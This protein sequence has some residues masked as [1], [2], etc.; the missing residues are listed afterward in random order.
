MLTRF[1]DYPV[2]QTAEPVAQVASGDRNFYDRYFFN[3]Y[4]AERGLFFG[5]ALGLYPNRRVMDAAVSVLAEGRQHSVYASRLAPLERAETRV[6]PISVEVEEPLR[7]LRVRLARHGDGP[8]ADLRFH[9]RTQPVEEPRFTRRSEGRLVMD[10][11]RFTQFGS[12][13]GTLTVGGRRI[14]LARGRVAGSRDRSWGVRPVGEREGGAPGPAPQFFWLWAPLHFDGFCTHFDVNEEADGARWHAFGTR[15][16]A[17]AADAPADAPLPEGAK[18]MAQVAHTVRWQPGTRRAAQAT[19]TLSPVSGEALEIAL[20][21]V[22]TFQMLGLGYLH[23]EH[24]HGV[25][26]GAEHVAVEQ[27]EP[28][29]LPPLDPRHLHVQQLCRARLGPHRGV[30][31]LEQLVIGPHAPS[32]FSGLLDGAA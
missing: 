30:G 11:T 19:L 28:A 32:G 27:W 24:G 6:G 2:H 18:A 9:A 31:V 17:L 14:D 13:E 3:G 22:L 25:W 7:R 21:P 23:P 12:W 8:E 10:T 29:K 4:D 20:E 5:V 15:V 26:R 16:P 1:D